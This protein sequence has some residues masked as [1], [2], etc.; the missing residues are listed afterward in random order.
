V[1]IEVV[2]GKMKGRYYT[3]ET[4]IVI[5]TSTLRFFELAKE[6]IEFI[7][8]EDKYL[9]VFRDQVEVILGKEDTLVG[10]LFTSK[11]HFKTS[12]IMCIDQFNVEAARFEKTFC[13]MT[14]MANKIGDEKM[15]RKLS[16]MTHFFF[17][18]NT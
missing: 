4:L 6:F 8:S 16:D 13:E 7:D 11:G 17:N 2:V 1:D 10:P 14:S 18:H 15:K 3:D 5:V 12:P 9:I